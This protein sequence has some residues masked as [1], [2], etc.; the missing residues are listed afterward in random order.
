[1]LRTCASRGAQRVTLYCVTESSL[2]YLT[3]V[4]LGATAAAAAAP[5]AAMPPKRVSALF[6]FRRLKNRSGWKKKEPDADD[7]DAVVFP[8]EKLGRNYDLNWTICKY[9]VVPNQHGNAFRNLHLRGLQMFSDAPIDKNKALLIKVPEEDYAFSHHFVLPPPPATTPEGNQPAELLAV[10]ESVKVVSE[11]VGKNTSKEVRRFLSE[12]KLLFVH[13]GAVGS[14]SSAE[15]K[16]RFIVSNA[17][18]ALFLH[19]VVPKQPLGKVQDF[20]ENLT[21]FVAPE[22][23]VTPDKLGVASKKFTLVNFKTNQVFVV[24]TH[25][26]EAIQQAVSSLATYLIG[27]KGALPVQCDSALTKDGKS[28]LLFG[29]GLFQ[30]K[31]RDD[32]FG[33]YGH[34]WSEHGV[35]RLFDGTLVA[36]PDSAFALN[37]GDLLYQVT[38]GGQTTKTSLTVPLKLH[39]HHAEH[40]SAVV[41]ISR[42]ATS[43]LTKISAEDAAKLYLSSFQYPVAIKT[44]MLKQRFQW[45]LSNKSVTAYQMGL[46]NGQLNVDELNTK[47]KTSLSP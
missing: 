30:K 40:P 38:K 14:H 36:N 7:L 34:T 4:R 6:D 33:S 23:D 22:L 37:R 10:P 45:L 18:T 32:A 44:D 3:G 27:K 35:S 11:V 2:L 47:L 17:N 9:A 29:H 24:G 21:I 39:G 8:R 12:G 15:E 20:I 26:P 16:V 28:V 19:H 42:S 1:M 31:P 43:G 41:F 5:G 25:A 46:E 13:D